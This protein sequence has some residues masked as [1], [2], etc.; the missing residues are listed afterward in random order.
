MMDYYFGL[1]LLAMPIA[2]WS[3]GL[4]STGY[5]S[6]AAEETSILTSFR[7]VPCY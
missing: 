7:K 4:L 5:V 6:H 1:A 3:T 2:Y